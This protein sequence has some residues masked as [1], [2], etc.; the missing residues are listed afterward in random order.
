LSILL[1]SLAAHVAVVIPLEKRALGE[2]VR[3]FALETDAV[4]SERSSTV[5][6]AVAN[7]RREKATVTPDVNGLVRVLQSVWPDFLSLEVIDSQGELIAMV[8]DLYLSDAGRPIHLDKPIHQALATQQY[9]GI[10]RDDPERGFFSVTV[11]QTASDGGPWFARAR[12][13]REPLKKLLVSSG[14]GGNAELLSISGR[15]SSWP[16]DASE[17][18]R[19]HQNW[20]GAP[21]GAEALLRTP[22]WMLRVERGSRG[23]W[24]LIVSGFVGAAVFLV[25]ALARIRPWLSRR[26]AGQAE[27]ATT[28]AGDGPVPAVT[29]PSIPCCAESP[30]EGKHPQETSP[31]AAR[32]IVEEDLEWLEVT[33]SEP[34][35]QGS[36]RSN[37]RPIARYWGS[38]GA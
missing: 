11:K 17:T 30:E 7:L 33:W 19:T 15:S 38:A 10:F 37:D 24:F 6:M 20:L 9:H 5:E 1:I 13:S 26:S 3:R 35:K 32:A 14:A 28:A 2:Q 22:N 4:L 23:S 29:N 12:F 36:D 8:G 21:V 34:E 16:K 25:C 27:A 31:E 18:V